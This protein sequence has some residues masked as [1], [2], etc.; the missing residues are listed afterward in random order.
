MRKEISKQI[1][2][3]VT[4]TPLKLIRILK[5][6]GQPTFEMLWIQKGRGTK[7]FK[8]SIAELLNG[9]PDSIHKSSELV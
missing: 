5:Y 3:S 7:N 8:I 1:N 2:R 9:T 4:N 6:S